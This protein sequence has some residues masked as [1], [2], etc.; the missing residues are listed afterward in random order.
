[1]VIPTYQRPDLVTR[2]VGSALSQTL[3]AIEVIVVVDGGGSA[4]SDAL[5]AIDDPR[6]FVH[7]PG[8]RLGN[9][10]ARNAGV[11]LA[12]APWIAFL[13]DDDEWLPEKLE[14]Q[15]ALASS[16]PVRNPVVSCRMIARD[17]TGDRIWPRRVPRE[18]ESLS[19]YFFCRRTPFT[20]EGMVINSAIMAP[21]ELVLRVPFKSR[22]ARHVDPDWMLRA[23]REPGVEM[24]FVDE[25]K[26][27]VI[28]HV[29]SGR[30]RITN[31]PDWKV[32]L[33]W[34]R[35]NRELFTRRSYAAFVLH[36]AGSAAAAQGD[37]AA[38]ASLLR[39]AFSKGTPAAVDL[40]SHVGNFVLP[41][42]VQRAL[43]SAYGRLS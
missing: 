26:P 11:S 9:A 36:V 20:G 13:D 6:L 2:A 1:V 10:D 4:T 15:L 21:R 33:A 5:N 23:V 43:A 35:E 42:T 16:T 38:F 14:L 19:E 28:W 34:C 30:A 39:E 41:K 29:E 3:G 27:L 32:S 37:F 7:V 12:R 22:L 31:Q 24:I 8:A 17:E 25:E 40:V 18:G